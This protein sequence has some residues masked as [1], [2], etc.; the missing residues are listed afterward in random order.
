MDIDKII[1]H[2]ENLGGVLTLKP[3]PGDGSPEVAWGDVFFYYAP[4]GVVPRTQPFA[5]VVTKDYQQD[6]A[7]DLDRPDTFR[8][9]IAAG[10]PAY[11]SWIGSSPK[12]T[13]TDGLD[14]A[15]TDTVLPHP[16]YG[17]M[18]W[19]C[20]VNPDAET[21]ATVEDLLREAH[22]LARERYHRRDRSGLAGLSRA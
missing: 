18:G 8:V 20:V 22:R 6:K 9:N 19:L 1:G 2:V 14:F 21:T 5:T 17:R 16:V 7:S 3:G 11:I 10:T 12:E 13:D 15:A 4:D